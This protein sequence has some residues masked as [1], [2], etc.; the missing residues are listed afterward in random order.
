VEVSDGVVIPGNQ[1]L[2]PHEIEAR[3]AAIHTPYHAYIAQDLKARD[4]RGRSTVLICQHSFTPVMAGEARPWHV[5]VL[6]LGNSPISK[7]MLTLLA[8]EDGLIADPAGQTRVAALL[9]RLL[10]FALTMASR[11]T[12]PRTR[13]S[14]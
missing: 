1:G 12:E 7:A 6:H 13:P 11:D 4:A 2:S 9:G 10:P 3:I 5:G 8:R 14:A